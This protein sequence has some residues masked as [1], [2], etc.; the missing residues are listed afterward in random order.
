[1]NQTNVWKKKNKYKGS[2][3]PCIGLSIAAV[4]VIGRCFETVYLG[5]WVPREDIKL[6]MLVDELSKSMQMEK[7]T[8]LILMDFSEALDKIDHERLL[9]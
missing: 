2:F 7:Q 1:M 3:P 5:T 6:I 9:L 4:G 8:N